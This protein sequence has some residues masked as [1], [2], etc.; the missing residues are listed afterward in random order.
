MAE[1][2]KMEW[3]VDDKIGVLEGTNPVESPEVLK[4]L[5]REG[6]VQVVTVRPWPFTMA[7]RLPDCN[8]R[9]FMVR[10]TEPSG[11]TPRD[12]FGLNEFC[13]YELTH[14]R[15]VPIWFEDARVREI[16]AASISRFFADGLADL[17]RFLAQAMATQRDR[18][19]QLPAEA[20][21]PTGCRLC[22]DGLC[23]GDLAC[24]TTDVQGAVGIVRAGRILSA[25][26][27]H[28]VS[29]QEMARDPRNAAGDPPDYFHYIMFG[30]GNCTAVDKL[31]FERIVGHVPSWEEFE[32]NFQP[33][34]RF[35]FRGDDLRAH[36]SWAHDG[37]QEKI[38]RELALDPWLVLM[39][40]PEGVAGSDELIELA[41]RQLPPD[42][43]ASFSF[44]GMDCRDWARMVYRQAKARER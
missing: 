41:R 29:G 20:P 11:L 18:F 10:A 12:L 4:Q 37:F 21:R 40:V 27:A 15:R 42:E 44:K 39:V 31:V 14:G 34:V 38:R 36:P 22:H 32:A 16:V 2:L 6:Y 23:Y 17:D 19:A 25:Y 35:F 5:E 3:L 28:G 30:P 9:N 33:G 1:S 24:H 43:V 13:V 7:W 8:L 26:R